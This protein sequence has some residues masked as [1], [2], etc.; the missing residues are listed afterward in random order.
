M[1]ALSS[2]G[3]PW[4]GTVLGVGCKSL[5]GCGAAAVICMLVAFLHG[6]LVSWVESGLPCMLLRESEPRLPACG[7]VVVA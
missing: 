7:V 1:C 4:M 5:H 2:Y 6:V 3:A